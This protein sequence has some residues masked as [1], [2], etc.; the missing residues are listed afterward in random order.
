MFWHLQ[1]DQ[2]PCQA[3]LYQWGEAPLGILTIAHL[4]LEPSKP[5]MRR[6]IN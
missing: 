3:P 1:D 6:G 4:G 5:H 2:D